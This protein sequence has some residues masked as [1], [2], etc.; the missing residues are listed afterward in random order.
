LSKA[1]QSKTVFGDETQVQPTT[2][3]QGA[4][5]SLQRRYLEERAELQKTNGYLP[6]ECA[7]KLDRME[8]IAR[9]APLEALCAIPGYR[10]KRTRRLQQQLYRKVTRIYGKG[11]VREIVVL[12]D[13]NTGWLPKFRMTIIPRDETGL[14]Y[15]DLCLVLELLPQFKIVLLEIALDF[16]LASVVDTSF[17]RQHLLCGKTWLRMG[18]TALHQRWGSARSAKVV[19]AYVKF[20]TSSSRLELQLHSR[21]LR[22]HGINH[23]SD[24]P[25]LATILP[26]HHI[27]FAALDDNKLQ[28]HLRRSGLSHKTRSK[29]LK[30]VAKS[31]KSL[32]C[33]LRLLRR[34]WRFANVRR[35]LSP[36]PEMNQ[37]VIAA[38]NQWAKQWQKQSTPRSL[39]TTKEREAQ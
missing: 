33:T 1:Q 19:R 37:L 31:R 7:V 34:Q 22:K 24:F 20:E 25:R 14:L 29:I 38:L 28:K 5:K 39:S 3:M 36:L 11:S 30:T 35:L 4:A 27:Y 18:G 17:V 10:A 21:F 12:W 6:L 23:A 8:I 2:K 13:P 9:E 16:P 15:G 32:W 26:G